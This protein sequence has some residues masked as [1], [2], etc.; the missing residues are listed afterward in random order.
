MGVCHVIYFKYL[1]LFFGLFRPSGGKNLI[2]KGLSQL[3]KV[4]L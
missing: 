2:A 3:Y 1:S 4:K